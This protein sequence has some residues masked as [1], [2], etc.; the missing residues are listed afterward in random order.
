V[1][2]TALAGLLHVDPDDWAVELD[3]QRVFFERFGHRLPVE[4]WRQHSALAKRL[5]LV[6]GVSA[7]G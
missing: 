1:S 2:P 6:P 4:I 5:G 7:A 3:D